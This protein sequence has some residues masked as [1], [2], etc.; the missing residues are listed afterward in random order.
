VSGVE[1]A[2]RT[3]TEGVSDSLIW[4]SS[5]VASLASG[6]VLAGL[7]YGALGALGLGLVALGTL[8]LFRLRRRIPAETAR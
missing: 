8:A 6:F 4:G 7:G 2:E 5:A 1:H 3:R